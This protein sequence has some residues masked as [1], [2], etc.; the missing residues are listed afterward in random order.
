VDIGGHPPIAIGS[1]TDVILEVL[2]FILVVFFYLSD[3]KL[4]GPF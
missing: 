4:S 3:P 2:V 1:H